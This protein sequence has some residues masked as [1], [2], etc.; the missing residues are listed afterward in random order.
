MRNRIAKWRNER[1]LT[2][3]ELAELVSAHYTTINR[4]ENGKQG[5]TQKWITKLA[6]ALEVHP[7][8][9]LDEPLY[10]PPGTLDLAQEAEL[11][12]PDEEH[13]ISKA[14]L[15]EQRFFYQ[16]KSNALDAIDIPEGAVIIADFDTDAVARIKE[17][18][19]ESAAVLIQYHYDP[20]DFSK[21]LILPRQF[22]PPRTLMRNSRDGRVDPIVL[23]DGRADIVATIA[24]VIREL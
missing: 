10:P 16:I 20:N 2:Q 24:S 17:G 19:L 22:I 8:D 6:E 21:C 11:Y 4:L 5:L 9:L 13:W 15:G 7:A 12:Q 1:G 3:E 14:K 23:G 18:G